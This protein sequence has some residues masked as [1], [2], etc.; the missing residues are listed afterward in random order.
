M[1]HV[2][3]TEKANPN[4]RIETFFWHGLPVIAL[5][6]WGALCVT[7]QLWYDEAF[8]AGLVMKPWKELIYITAVDD[9]SPFYYVALK[10]FYHLTGGGTHFWTLKAF[11]LL[12]MIGYML[13]GKYYVSKLFGRRVSVWFM[14]FSVL[15]PIMSVQ[16]GNVRMYSMALFFLTFTGL[17]AYDIYKSSGEENKRGKKWLLFTL[18]TICVVYC[19]SF[20]VIQAVWLYIIFMVALIKSRQFDKLKKFFIGGIVVSVVFSPWLLVTLKQLQL[21]MLY[22]TG[23]ATELAKVSALWDYCREWFSAIETP[24]DL[25]AA[26]GLLVCVLL[27]MC[28]LAWMRR[29]QNYAPVLGAA[30]FL[31]TSLTGFVISVFINNCFMGR[32]AFPGFGF[33]VLLMAVGMSNIRFSGLRWGIL[34]VA[35]GCFVVQYGSEL[36][37]EYDGG[38]QEYETFWVEQVG[39]GDVFI[40]PTGHAVFP[41]VYHPETTYYLYGYV[42]VDLSFP[43]LNECYDLGQLVRDNPTVWY[44]CFAGDSPADVEE[45]LQFEEATSFRYMYYDF[46]IY[47]M[48]E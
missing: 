41:G 46:V 22:D 44:I 37:L 31:L 20:A 25:V 28:A 4:N 40:A 45:G 38:L 17:L 18:A 6:I 16:A 29:E 47:R 5:L 13:L 24:I 33:I 21:R 30:A 39:E 34:A 27:S 7:N 3:K 35:L 32:Y 26:L 48:L 12:F 14:T 11:S 10:L 15:A 43:N 2:D 8:S 9:H 36:A 1:E 23:S 42:P 19:H